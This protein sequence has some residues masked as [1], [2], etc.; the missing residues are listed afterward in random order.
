VPLT[1]ATTALLRDYLAMHPRR[2]EPTAPLFPN[3]RLQPPRPAGIADPL[4]L[5]QELQ[6]PGIE[7]GSRETAHRQA[8][9]LGDLSTAEA[10]ERLVLDWTAPNRHA[11]FYKAVF[12][13]AV[14][15]A[16]RLAAV[17]GDLAAALPP[18]LKFHARGNVREP[19]YR[20]GA[21]AAGGRAVH[22]PRQGH[23]DAGRLR[24]PVC[25][26]LR[27]RDGCSRGDG[28]C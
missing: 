1:P 18:Q 13:P 8:T 20:G 6:Q 11:T 15:R 14:L 16:N 25:R 5:N 27:R 17:R 2:N 24:T 19:L 21:A 7:P 10:G 12:R 3:V 26:R 28:D 4:T 9:A 22:G 23:H